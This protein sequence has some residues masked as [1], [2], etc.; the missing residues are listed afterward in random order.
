MKQTDGEI[1]EIIISPILFFKAKCVYSRRK[2]YGSC[3]GGYKSV[4]I[5][6]AMII[7]SLKNASCKPTCNRDSDCQVTER[8]LGRVSTENKRECCH[9]TCLQH[10]HI[11]KFQLSG[12]LVSKVKKR[13]S[14]AKQSI[15]EQVNGASKRTWQK[16]DC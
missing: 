2:H 3:P 6:Q 4:L 1:D 16:A 15:A 9:E 7:S 11:H 5:D 10:E 14:M 12:E 13:A 8:Y